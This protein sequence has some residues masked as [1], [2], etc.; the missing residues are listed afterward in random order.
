LRF[1]WCLAYLC[2]GGLGVGLNH[3]RR[4]SEEDVHV[5]GRTATGE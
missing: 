1:P 4:P 2:K 5:N 3:M